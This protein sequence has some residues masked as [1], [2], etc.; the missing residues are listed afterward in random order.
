MISAYTVACTGKDVIGRKCPRMQLD[1]KRICAKCQESDD[2]GESLF[3]QEVKDWRQPYLIFLQHWVLSPY[4]TDTMK[5]QR[6]SSKF[7]VEDSPLFGRG[8]N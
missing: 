6:K 4:R 8:F 3:G 1:F 7:F 2:I 5:V